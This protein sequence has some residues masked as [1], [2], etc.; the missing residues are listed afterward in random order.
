[1][2]RAAD[3]PLA[4]VVFRLRGA[5]GPFVVVAPDGAEAV[6]DT[7]PRA[8]QLACAALQPGARARLGCVCGGHIAGAPGRSPADHRVYMMLTY[9]TRAPGG[10]EAP[11]VYRLRGTVGPFMVIM[12]GGVEF[13]AQTLRGALRLACELLP[14]EA[15]VRLGCLCGEHDGDELAPGEV[16]RAEREAGGGGGLL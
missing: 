13:V 8:W 2:S 6:A 3:G 15:Q 14:F 1:M 7:L 9:V 10:P 5:A 11:I 16:G 12:P 4:P